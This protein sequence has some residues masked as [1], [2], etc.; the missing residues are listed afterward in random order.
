MYP[1]TEVFIGLYRYLE[2]RPR[3]ERPL[4]SIQKAISLPSIVLLSNP[5]QK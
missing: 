3:Q 1:V 4:Q 2:R 5:K